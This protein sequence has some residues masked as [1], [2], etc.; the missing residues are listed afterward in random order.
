MSQ[1]E[2]N[3]MIEK[4]RLWLNNEVGGV[5]LNLSG[6]YLSDADLRY[7]NLS[8]ANLSDANLRY[9]NLRNADLNYANLRYVKAIAFIE[10]MAKDYDEKH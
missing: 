9:A 5:R 1:T 4:H 8:D 3:E 10:Y 2:L 7:A 6:A